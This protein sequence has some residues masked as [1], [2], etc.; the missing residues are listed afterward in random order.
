MKA[1]FGEI[2]LPLISKFLPAMKLSTLNG[3]LCC[4]LGITLLFSGCA[5]TQDGR[6]TQMQGTAIGAGAGAVLGGLTGALVSGGDTGAIVGGA[7]IGAGVGGL[8]GFIWGNH[9]AQKKEQYRRTEEW[10]DACIVSAQDA[11]RTAR[12][13]NRDLNRRLAAAEAR[14]RSARAAGNTAELVRIKRELARLQREAEQFNRQLSR[15]IEVQ[16]S[17]LRDSE[18]RSSGNYSQLRNEVNQL[19]QAKGQANT[20]VNRISTAQRRVNG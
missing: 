10:L 17:A 11:N 12:Q 7:A 1:R 14:A 20:T 9:V 5:E 19:Q 15:E 3:P 6:N 18:A 8:G 16:Q 2:T 4:A 13:T